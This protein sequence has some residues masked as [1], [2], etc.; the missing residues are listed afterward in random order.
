MALR[1]L[2]VA[3]RWAIFNLP[4]QVAKEEGYFAAEGLEVEF[5]MSEATQFGGP[6][7][8][9]EDLFGE[10]RT[11]ER[12]FHLEATID[13]Y[14]TC[15]W[16]AIKRTSEGA[17]AGKIIGQ[18]SSVVDMAIVASPKSRIYALRDLADVPI[19]TSFYNGDHFLILELVGGAVG[20]EQVRP[21]HYGH[22][23]YHERVRRLV[24]GEAVA[25]TFMEPYLSLVEKN[26]GRII[27]ETYF[28]G[29][30]VGSPDLDAETIR[31]IF[32]AL[33]RAVRKINADIAP[34]V[35]RFVEEANR[36]AE[37]LEKLQ[38]EDFKAHRLRYV[39]P[40]PYTE[41]EFRR[42][43]DWMVQ[44]DLV[45]PDARYEELVRADIVAV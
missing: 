23:G 9:A 22:G 34:Y 39:E 6:R 16:G 41:A 43:Y 14:N 18:R 4:W 28:R 7:T 38:P 25:G 27:T 40:E 44:W 35:P 2:R 17:R 37:G 32:R 21:V 12:A 29:A 45:R 31:G 20:R 33:G 5:A 15:E 3:D 42:T 11:K 10:G 8:Y 36:D 1:K 13:T 24:S 30:D 26:G 19:E